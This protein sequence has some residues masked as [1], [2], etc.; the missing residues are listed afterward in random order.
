VQGGT[1]YG[2]FPQVTFNTSED[3]GQGSLLPTTS[4]DQ[5]AATLARWFGVADARMPEVLPNIANFGAARYLGF[6]T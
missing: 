1:I 2:T 5:Y 6:L 4:V 3:V